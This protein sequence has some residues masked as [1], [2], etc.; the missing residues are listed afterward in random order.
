MNLGD[1]VGGNSSFS[2]AVFTASPSKT[3]IGI[4]VLLAWNV[5]EDVENAVMDQGIGSVAGV[6]SRL[7]SPSTNEK[8]TISYG[9]NQSISVTVEVETDHHSG[10]PL[11]EKKQRK[12][13]SVEEY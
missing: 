12:L 1:H 8:Y 7:V 3:K 10:L 11:P 2:S 5:G 13:N 9:D 4:A 6:G